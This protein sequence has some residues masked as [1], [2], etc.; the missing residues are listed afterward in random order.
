MVTVALGPID[1]SDGQSEGEIIG[2]GDE[3]TTF[4]LSQPTRSDS[5]NPGTCKYNL[6]NYFD[7][8]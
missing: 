5:A 1:A 6:L 3:G 2:V 8:Y 4:I 7:T